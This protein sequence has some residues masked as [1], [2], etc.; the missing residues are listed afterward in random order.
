VTQIQFINL[1]KASA[2]HVVLERGEYAYGMV[3]R[4]S[5]RWLRGWWYRWEVPATHS[6]L[7][8]VHRCP[9]RRQFDRYLSLAAAAAAADASVGQTWVDWLTA[10]SWQCS[11]PAAGAAAASVDLMNVTWHLVMDC[12]CWRQQTGRCPL[13]PSSRSS[14][15]RHVDSTAG[16]LLCITHKVI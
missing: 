16:S 4:S 12:Q 10:M 1:C 7:A 6:V 11:G 8:S 13:Q 2:V 15:C 5:G 3:A 9:W 14:G